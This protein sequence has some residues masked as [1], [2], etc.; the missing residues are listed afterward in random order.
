MT[1]TPGELRD[2]RH[3]ILIA[4]NSAQPKHPQ[5]YHNLKANPECE[6]GGEKFVAAEVTDPDEYVRLYAL[7]EQVYAGYADYRVKTAPM[8]R[9]IPV[10]R[11]TSR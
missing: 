9:K 3:P 5:W 11:L 2:G 8:G 10:F 7:A 4:S 1:D 6:F